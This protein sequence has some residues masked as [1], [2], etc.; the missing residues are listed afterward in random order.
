[1][2]Y[3]YKFIKTKSKLSEEDVNNILNE[4]GKK[5]W[6]LINFHP[7]SEKELSKKGPFYNT[8]AWDSG[9]VFTFMR[10]LP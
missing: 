6:K 2:N 4:L 1:M 8:E 10:E 7:T 9:Y 5:G 3:E